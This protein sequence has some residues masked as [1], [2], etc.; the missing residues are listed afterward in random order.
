MIPTLRADRVLP[1][2]TPN[3]R[4]ACETSTDFLHPDLDQ[5]MIE[6]PSFDGKRWFAGN[7][8]LYSPTVRILPLKPDANITE[9]ELNAIWSASSRPHTTRAM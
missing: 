4:T 7:I 2:R 8:I 9:A 6:D 1:V 3:V 5:S